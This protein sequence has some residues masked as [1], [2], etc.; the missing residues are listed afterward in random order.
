MWLSCIT[1]ATGWAQ[2]LQQATV[3][4]VVLAAIVDRQNRPLVDVGADDFVITEN[5]QARDVLD[6]HIADYP[7]VLLVD[8][9]PDAAAAL[10]ALTT[11]VSRFI[12]R[13][14]ERPIAVGTLGRAGQLVASFDDERAEVQRRVKAI[15]ASAVEAS[16]SPLDAIANAAALLRQ[17]GVPFSAIVIATAHTIGASAAVS[18]EVV[19]S[20]LDSGAN[21]QVITARLA[22]DLKPDTSDLLRVLADQTHGQYT[23]IFSPAS[24]AIALDR[25][26]DRMATELMIE[27]VAP[28]KSAAGDVKIGA[29]LPGARIIGLGV[30]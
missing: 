22:G 8:D 12:A 16:A 7:V 27:Y 5:G 17:A 30:R 10:P 29:R 20:I 25:I 2:P 11:A 6:V 15:G 4:R 23:R 14:G 9:A 19:R 1:I 21:I 28:A 3:G 26:A 13:I 24:Y 18:P